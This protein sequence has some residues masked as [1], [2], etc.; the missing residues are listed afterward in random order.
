VKRQ[1]FSEG[2]FA[3][4]AWGK[5]TYLARRAAYEARMGTVS[6][7]LIIDPPDSFRDVAKAARWP[8]WTS[9]RDF[10]DALSERGFVPRIN[11]FCFGADQSDVPKYKVVFDFAV[12]LGD[13]V[14]IVDECQLFAPKQRRCQPEIVKIAAMGRHLPDRDGVERQVCLIVAS[15]T[16]TGINLDVRTQIRTVVAGRMNGA[17]NHRMLVAEV[18]ENSEEIIDKLKLHEFVVLDP[19]GA[20]MPPLAPMDA[21]SG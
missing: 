13:C 19:V 20:P 16:W 17:A 5:T 8:R 3:G 10:D 9:W 15:Q 11:V 12:A 6:S 1:Y 2:V 18:N 7:V 21:I 14:L 4:K